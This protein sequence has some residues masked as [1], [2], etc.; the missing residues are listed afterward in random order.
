M[1]KYARKRVTL[2]AGRSVLRNDFDLGRKYFEYDIEIH[3]L[4]KTTLR[5]SSKMLG[6]LYMQSVLSH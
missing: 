6:V 3:A 2:L 1:C 5:P 4:G